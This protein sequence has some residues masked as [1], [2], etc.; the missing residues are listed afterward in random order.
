MRRLQRLT[1]SINQL[2]GQVPSGLS[3]LS[4]LSEL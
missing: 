4:T 2:S 1:L 3:G